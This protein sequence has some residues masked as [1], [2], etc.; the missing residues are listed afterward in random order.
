[1]VTLLTLMTLVQRLLVHLA[2][3]YTSKKILKTFEV[4][5][6]GMYQTSMHFSVLLLTSIET[7]VFDSKLRFYKFPNYKV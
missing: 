7:Q 5:S 1:M 4:L 6:L 3:R 2:S